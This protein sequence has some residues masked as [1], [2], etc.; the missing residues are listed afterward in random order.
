MEEFVGPIINYRL[1][2]EEIHGSDWADKPVRILDRTSWIL[3][4]L[5]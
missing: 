4:A 3:R 1:E 2:Q 5:L